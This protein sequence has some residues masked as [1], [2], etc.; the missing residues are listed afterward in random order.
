MATT[1]QLLNSSYDL[2]LVG[3]GT[4]GCVLANR[5]SED[6]TLRIL[7]IEAGSD[8]SDDDA[9]RIPGLFTTLPGDDRYDWKFESEP[10]VPEL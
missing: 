7:L 8:H 5:F 4:A 3:A 10:E 9:V 2:I 1:H 6:S